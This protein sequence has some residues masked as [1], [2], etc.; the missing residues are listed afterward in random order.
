MSSLDWPKL[1]AQGRAKDNGVAWS[2]EEQEALSAL[3]EHTGLDRHIVAPYVRE[4]ILTVKDYEAAKAKEGKKGKATE[5]KSRKEL[6]KEA[7]KLGVDIN[8]AMSDSTIAKLVKK[9]QDDLDAA[10]EEAEEE[11]E[12]EDE[13]EEDAEDATDE[14]EKS[15]E[16][17]APPVPPVRAPKPVK[18]TTAK[19]AAKKGNK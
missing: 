14:G 8:D 4:G 9:A 18:K 10:S 6:E 13:S 7:A 15:P 16:E 3:I 5:H 12:S 2:G 17:D 19:K 11:E 1:V